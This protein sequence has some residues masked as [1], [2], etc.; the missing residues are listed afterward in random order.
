MRTR[1]SRLVVFIALMLVMAPS[2]A[3]AQNDA[4]AIPKVQTS[5][6]VVEGTRRDGTDVYLGIPYALPP[7]GE[8]RL[9][10]PVAAA[11]RTEPLRATIP[12]SACTATLLPTSLL[13][14]MS[15]VTMPPFPKVRSR[16]P[17]A[18]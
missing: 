4:S 11:A 7:T 13:P 16:S 17:G 10:A 8:R 3:S 5:L 1:H 18:A 2:A 14:P 9:A 6:G 15:V 12:P